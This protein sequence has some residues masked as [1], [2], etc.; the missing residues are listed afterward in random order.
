MIDYRLDRGARVRKHI[1]H[2][3]AG[4]FVDIGDIVKYY[5]VKN[6]WIDGCG[7]IAVQNNGRYRWFTMSQKHRGYIE[8][9]TTATPGFGAEKRRWG[10]Q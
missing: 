5:N 2:Y 4:P 1:L 6:I 8:S 10:A 7:R 9:G 3:G